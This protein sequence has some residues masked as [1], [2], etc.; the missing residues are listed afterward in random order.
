VRSWS[1][2]KKVGPLLGA[3]LVLLTCASA[4]KPVVDLCIIDYGNG[5]ANCGPT[6]KFDPIPSRWVSLKDLNNNVCFSP[7][8]WKLIQNYIDGLE[9]EAGY[10]Q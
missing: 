8:D 2:W 5:Q 4:P 10:L 7:D 1:A 6:V 9:Y 3:S